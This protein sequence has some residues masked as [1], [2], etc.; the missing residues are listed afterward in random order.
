VTLT[1]AAGGSGGLQRYEVELWIFEVWLNETF[2][3]A[4]PSSDSTPTV[5]EPPLLMLPEAF[6]SITVSW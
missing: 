5:A 3:P 2:V 6:D 4:A 1:G